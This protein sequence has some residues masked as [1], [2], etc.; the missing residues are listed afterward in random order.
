M[1][2][3]YE[4]FAETAREMPDAAAV[5]DENGTLTYRELDQLA[6][7]LQAQFP[8]P[9][10]SV[11]IVMDH[12]NAMIA[13]ILA[14]LR[15]GAAY[16]PVEPD[17]PVRRMQRMFRDA[18][19]SFVIAS[20][21]YA[22]M[23]PDSEVLIVDRIE[24]PEPASCPPVHVDSSDAAYVLFTSGSTGRPK[25][26]IVENRNVLHYARAFAKEFGI[27]PGDVMLQ[28]SVCTFDI[29]VEEV[30]GT[31][32]NGG[33]LLVVS[34]SIRDNM[35][36][37]T[38]YMER[39]GAT[40]VSGFPYLLLELSRA[41]HL[42]E[43]LR[44][45]ISGGDVL[46]SSYVEQILDSGIEIYNTYGPSETTCCA[47]YERCTPDGALE[48]GTFPVGCP[49]EGAEVRILSAEGREAATGE[50][51]EITIFGGGVARGYLNHSSD[52]FTEIDG[53]RA[54]RSGDL[55]YMLP[56]G[57][58]VFV[59]RMDTQ[60]MIYGRRVETGE[61][62]NVL[63]TLPGIASAHVLAHED[64]YGH[65][66]LTAY[67]VFESEPLSAG[68]LREQLAEELP[69]YMIPEYFVAM[70]SVPLTPNG[71]PDTSAFPI[72]LKEGRLR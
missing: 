30:F 19:V 44:L 9:A 22:P 71:K 26:I 32:L 45:L 63:C 40:I 58:I 4:Q 62:E 72:V 15:A 41:G 37:L 27:G 51:G 39:H 64:E 53:Q 1:Q 66:Y 16:V 18:E 10:R 8:R 21:Q 47:T 34:A 13:A 11:G 69:H 17:F 2:T 31:L 35:E 54:F 24:P 46:R 56:S 7:T 67:V 49:V 25:G 42:P 23:L 14:V 12:S 33:E 59:R 52:G 5:T 65:A 36:Q 48:N 57:E 29:F 6:Q 38:A 28:H 68:E 3:I 50:T 61:V 20:P 60:V 55:G 43:S 70:P